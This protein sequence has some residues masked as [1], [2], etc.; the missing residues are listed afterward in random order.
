MVVCAGVVS[1]PVT[2]VTETVVVCRVVVAFGVVAAV[3]VVV[4]FGVVAAVVVVVAFVVVVVA[5][6]VVVPDS[7]G[8]V[9]VGSLTLASRCL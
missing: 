7:A 8:A 3:V 2:L 5:A 1:D 4:A 6:V 9:P